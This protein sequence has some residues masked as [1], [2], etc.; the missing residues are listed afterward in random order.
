MARH[1]L[2]SVFLLFQALAVTAQVLSASH[3]PTLVT[4]AKGTT[5]PPTGKVVA[6]VNGVALTDI[7]LQREMIAM[8]PY[9]RQHGGKIPPSMEAEVRRGA[10]Q[11]IEFEEL[12]YQEAVRRKL[13]VSAGRLNKALAEFKSQVGSDIQFQAFLK[14][15]FGGSQERLRQ[16]IQRSLLID[17]LLDLEVTRRSTVSDTQV[18]SYYEQ[19]SAKYRVPA[20]VSIQTISI[21]IPDEATAEQEATARE[22]ADGIL[23]RARAAKNYEEFGLL[24]ER[25][26]DDDWR[27][28]MG[29]HG[30]VEEEKMPPQVARVVFGMKVG[31]VS[32]LIRADNSFCIVRLSG[33]EA[34]RQ[35]PFEQVKAEIRKNLQAMRVDQ[36]RSALN[37]QLR[38][39]AKV[40][41][42]S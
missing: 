23:R 37:R 19:N 29:D 12:V 15:E 26:S 30:A 9:A 27:V 13:Q 3:A 7:D 22:H 36:L 28:M 8:F 21:V 34:A 32:E 31:Q 5:S 42:V 39:T 10:L 17:D 33:R 24:A 25:V 1:F 40:E 6:R 35:L 18:R 4:P 2:V 11:M 14:S 38:K 41:E 16:S 20:K